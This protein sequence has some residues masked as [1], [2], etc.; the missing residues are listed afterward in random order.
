[1]NNKQVSMPL[2]NIEKRKTTFDEVALGYTPEQAIDEAARC[3]GCKSA[4]CMQGCPVGVKI[5]DFI[6]LIQKGDFASA[7]AKVEETNSLGSICGRVCPQETQCQKKCVRGIKGESVA[8][9]RLERF[10]CDNESIVIGTLVDPHTHTQPHSHNVAIIGSGP[11]GLACAGELAKNGVNVTVFE[12]LHE[13]G[14]VLVYGIPEFRLPKKGVARQVERLK[15]MGVEFQNNVVI[16]KTI[17]LSELREKFD[18][19]LPVKS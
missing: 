6:K 14:G 9:G 7:K 17:S 1:M 8:I 2:L 18:A 16:G 12:A 3:L 10:A 4:P 13:Y 15:N 5:A 11:A 19:I